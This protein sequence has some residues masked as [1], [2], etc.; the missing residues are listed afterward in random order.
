MKKTLIVFYNS[1][2]VYLQP[3]M[4]KKGLGKL[5]KYSCELPEG[6]D[7]IWRLINSFKGDIIEIQKTGG[8]SFRSLMLPAKDR[9]Q[10]DSMLP[11]QV[12]LLSGNTEATLHESIPLKCV[13]KNHQACLLVRFKGSELKSFYEKDRFNGKTWMALSYPSVLI[14]RYLMA[15]KVDDVDVLHHEESTMYHFIIRE[16]ELIEATASYVD[17]D[18]LSSEKVIRQIEDRYRVS[19]HRVPSCVELNAELAPILTG[20]A[21]L[22]GKVV[23]FKCSDAD[24]I[25]ELFNGVSKA[26]TD[27]SCR[28]RV[29]L[30]RGASSTP[31][32]YSL[33]T[34]GL[35]CFA[36]M[37]FLLV[38]WGSGAFRLEQYKNYSKDLNDQLKEHH[39]IT[40]EAG[41]RRHY[42]EISFMK[43]IRKE[44][45]NTQNDSSEQLGFREFVTSLQETLGRCPNFVCQRIQCQPQVGNYKIQGIVDDVR[46]FDLL[47]QEFE[48]NEE[49]EVKGNFTRSSG[50]VKG[51]KVNL[52]IEVKR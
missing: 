42:T 40:L 5:E 25:S 48:R 47:S 24:G 31:H 18:A 52:N 35:P 16:G 36:G 1:K 29:L 37:L 10:L 21:N 44:A 27:H 15:P 51:L 26:L 38:A 46:A 28:P 7:Q 20:E 11:H 45:Q 17:S 23:P 43:R 32:T 33:G 6:Q 13:E 4:G 49:W 8:I 3:L 50:R 2:E 34:W 9:H 30:G 14:F 39:Q 12:K 41:Q 19:G 22:L